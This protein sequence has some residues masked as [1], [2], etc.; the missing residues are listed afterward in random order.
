MNIKIDTDIPILTDSPLAITIDD[1]VWAFERMGV[2]HSFALPFNTNA[3]PEVSP[4]L[5]MVVEAVARI[6]GA[7]QEDGRQF[8]S[9]CWAPVP[10]GIRVWRTY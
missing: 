2:G 10:G 9:W 8:F 1:I 7:D 6:R 5:R 3:A 4:L